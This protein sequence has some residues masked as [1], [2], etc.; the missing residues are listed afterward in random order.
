ME[1]RCSGFKKINLKKTLL[2][3]AAKFTTKPGKEKEQM[4][5]AIIWQNNERNSL[6]QRFWLLMIRSGSAAILI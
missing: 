5:L 4:A 3:R 1:S 6:Q 2:V